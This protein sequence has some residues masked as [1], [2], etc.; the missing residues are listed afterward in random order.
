MYLYQGDNNMDNKITAKLIEET[1][2]GS[3]IVEIYNGENLVWAHDYFANGATEQYMAYV[4]KQII[5]DMTDCEKYSNFDGCD[6][7]ENGEIVK[8]SDLS[9]SIVTLIY[10]SGQWQQLDVLNVGNLTN[11]LIIENQDRLPAHITAEHQE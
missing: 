2:G 10:L 4:L 11:E 7:D 8:A 3:L 6:L 1:S 5:D 9:T